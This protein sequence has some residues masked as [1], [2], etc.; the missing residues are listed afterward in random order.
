MSS[1]LRRLLSRIVIFERP[2]GNI[3]DLSASRI[4]SSDVPSVNEERVQV[5]DGTT[6]ARRRSTTI[7]LAVVGEEEARLARLMADSC[8]VGM[9]ALGRPGT[10]HLVWQEDAILS[11]V[12]SP[13]GPLQKAPD[14]VRL[15]TNVFNPSVWDAT[16]LVAG[17]PWEGASTLGAPDQA[18][19]LTFLSGGEMVVYDGSLEALFLYKRWD[20]P[21]FRRLEATLSDRG[22]LATHVRNGQEEIHDGS[23]L[24]IDPKDGS[25]IGSYSA[26]STTGGAY[27]K[28]GIAVA[29]GKL[30]TLSPTDTLYFYDSVPATGTVQATSQQDLSSLSTQTGESL[31]FDPRTGD[32]FSLFDDDGQLK[33]RR[34]DGATA[35]VTQTAPLTGSKGIAL[36]DGHLYGH[37]DIK[38]QE[39]GDQGG[40]G[41]ENTILRDADL[42]RPMPYF[43]GGATGD[44]RP[45]YS[46]PYWR[47][48]QTSSIDVEGQPTGVSSSHPAILEIVAPLIGATLRLLNVTGELDGI[49]W[50]GTAL[51]LNQSSR[52]GSPPEITLKGGKYSDLGISSAQ[53]WKLRMR[54]ESAAARPR[55]EVVDPGEALGARPGGTVSDCQN[56]VASP[57]WGSVTAIAF[58]IDASDDGT[59]LISVVDAV[60]NYVGQLSGDG[61]SVQGTSATFTYESAGVYTAEMVAQPN[62]DGVTEVD[63]QGPVDIASFDGGALPDVTTLFVRDGNADSGPIGTAGSDFVPADVTDLRVIKGSAELPLSVVPDQVI[64]LIAHNNQSSGF[65]SEVPSSAEILDLHNTKIGGEITSGSVPSALKELDIRRN[66]VT[67]KGTDGLESSNAL[68]TAPLE[69]LLIRGTPLRLDVL[70]EKVPSLVELNNFAGDGWRGDVSGQDANG[71]PFVKSDLQKFSTGNSIQLDGYF[72]DFSEA[73]SLNR[74]NFSTTW[75][76]LGDEIYPPAGKRIVDSVKAL[77]DARSTLGSVSVSIGEK[78]REDF[79]SDGEPEAYPVNN[80]DQQAGRQVMGLGTYHPDAGGEGLLDQGITFNFSYNFLQLSF[81]RESSTEVLVTAP[82]ETLRSFGGPDVTYRTGLNGHYKM[83]VAYDQSGDGSDQVVTI[84]LFPV[85]SLIRLYDPSS[86]TDYGQYEVASETYQGGEETIVVIDDTASQDFNG[87]NN[88]DLSQSIPSSAS[89]K[90]YGFVTWPR[91]EGAK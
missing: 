74:L 72:T 67:T 59:L 34:H 65:W 61:E 73:S 16:N 53:I 89:G 45:A 12:P 50:N 14:S 18:D 6:R 48:D 70:L 28:A 69:T 83:R 42:T 21:T 88:N 90:V 20:R 39:Y 3:L 62:F 87:D 11:R 33:V 27:P 5:A 77:H 31:A 80:L 7:D 51:N 19:G 1:I 13:S 32:L 23:G 63:L 64:T 40:S 58:D 2:T 35:T 54:V 66:D 9:I 4:L 49:D 47:N 86:N 60:G 82:D 85:G 52:I 25:T 79:D 55:L 91:A 76:D 81:S 41:V 17:V 56:R 29:N 8:P 26:V 37:T 36:F 24:R 68:A 22:A 10:K 75:N 78:R 46:G 71:N 43:P 38:V 15:E 30:I 57:A 84:R 44:R